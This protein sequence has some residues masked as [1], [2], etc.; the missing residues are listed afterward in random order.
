MSKYIDSLLLRGV[1]RVRGVG[2]SSQLLAQS[3]EQMKKVLQKEVIEPWLEREIKKQKEQDKACEEEWRKAK[4]IKL[5]LEATRHDPALITE[6]RDYSKWLRGE[7]KEKE[8]EAQEYERMLLT[9]ERKREEEK[10][11]S[12]Q[13]REQKLSR[14][15]IWIRAAYSRENYQQCGE[16]LVEWQQRAEKL[17]LQEEYRIEETRKQFQKLLN[18]V[19]EKRERE[20]LRGVV[21]SSSLRLGT[22]HEFTQ[23]AE[24]SYC[25][26][27]RGSEKLGSSVAL[28]KMISSKRER[29]LGEKHS[30]TIKC[31]KWL[32]LGFKQ[33]GLK[34]GL[35]S[36]IWRERVE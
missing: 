13:D 36:L 1:E 25:T 9:I 22:T 34:R 33:S 3:I 7:G 15:K 2:I 23:L 8:K 29:T 14:L 20:A 5:R 16:L 17:N 31:L 21:R 19:V 24:D 4:I 6:L 32:V 12:I 18:R 27:L 30:G 28:L 26:Y 11:A 35:V 10:A